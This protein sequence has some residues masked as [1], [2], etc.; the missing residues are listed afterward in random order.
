MQITQARFSGVVA[1]I[2]ALASCGQ[3][4]P[5]RRD[6]SKPHFNINTLK[7]SPPAIFKEPTVI[8]GAGLPSVASL[9][10]TSANLFD[11]HFMSVYLANKTAHEQATKRA[12]FPLTTETL[13][14]RGLTKRFP[15]QCLSEFDG[16]GYGTQAGIIAC[17][18][19]LNALGTTRCEAPRGG[20]VM[21]QAG[22][23]GFTS[24]VSGS[25]DETDTAASYCRDVATGVAF[26]LNNCVWCP[27]GWGDCV[28]QSE[29]AAYGN[30]D[31]AVATWGTAFP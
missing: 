26:G 19:Y 6:L 7:S 29:A 16:V 1:I 23:H 8:P 21:C 22:N 11:N 20:V 18:N 14:G 15:D 4:T 9:G 28:L 25:A 10:L 5:S 30:G 31:L 17:Y 12:P 13:S 2:V 27:G 3:A 24:Y